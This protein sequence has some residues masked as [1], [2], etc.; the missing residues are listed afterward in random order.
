MA[1]KELQKQLSEAKDRLIGKKNL[2]PQ[3]RKALE[4]LM[5]G[6]KNLEKQLEDLQKKTEELKQQEERQ[7]KNEQNE[8]IKEKT[9]QLQ[10]LLQDLLDEETK[11]LYDELKKLLEEQ[12]EDDKTR[13]LLE[14]IEKKEENLSKELDRALELFKQLAV[15]KKIDQTASKLEDL[16]KKQDELADKLAKEKGKDDAKQKELEKE[17]AALQEEFKQAKEDLKALQEMNKEL[18]QP[19]QMPDTDKQEEA[20]DA[21]QQEAKDAAAKKQNQKAGKAGKEA[22]KEMKEMADKMREAEAEG[23]AEQTEENEGDLRK[24]L[25]NLMKLSFDQEDLMKDFRGVNRLDPR[26]VQMGQTQLKLR[27]DAAVIED[28]LYALAKRVFQIQSFV[29]REMGLMKQN[30]DEAVDGFKARRADIAAGKGQLAMTSMNNLALL[31]NDALKQMQDAMKAQKP[32][33]GKPGKGKGKKKGKGSPGADGLGKMQQQLNDQIQQLKKGGKSGKGMSEELAKMAAQQQAI[34]KALGELERAKGGQGGKKPGQAAG[35]G[36]QGGKPGDKGQ[37]NGQAN[38]QAGGK[39]GKD[40]KEGKDGQKD[41]KDGSGGQAGD[42][43]TQM[44]KTEADLVNKRLTEETLLRQREILTRL[45]ETEKALQERGEEE[46]RE[47]KTAQEYRPAIPPELKQFVR[48]KE[49]EQS[50]LKTLAPDFTSFYRREAERY[51]RNLN[52][53]TNK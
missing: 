13:E 16:A 42:L 10:N 46:K 5:D 25:E 1:S 29:T 24:I 2:G 41:G 9:E 19:N 4:Q 32:G 15:E 12:Q 39:D 22:A 14:K 34:R 35:Q 38:G 17:Q 30:M 49:R 44:E 8:A 27:D 21:K 48:D 50:T 52:E 11:K 43:K 31:L 18:E 53:K 7:E 33:Q 3:E 40:G 37:T 20:V 45:L 28:S 36:G 51:F 6:Q 26:Y 47:S 23:E